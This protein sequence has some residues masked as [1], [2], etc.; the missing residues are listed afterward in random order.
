MVAWWPLNESTGAVVV[1]DIIGFN[2]QGTPKS[3]GSLG[4]ANSPAAIAGQVGGAVNFKSNLQSLATNTGAAN[5]EV[6]DHDEIDFGTGDLSIDAW[7]RM[8]APPPSDAPTQSRLIVGK[9]E[10]T[11]SALATTGTGYALSLVAS[12]ANGASLQFMMG[13]GGPLVS[14]TTRERFVPFDTWT[15]VVVT[16][17]RKGGKVAF[18]INGQLVPATEATMPKGSVS[19]GSSLLIGGSN[20]GGQ[21]FL[22]TIFLYPE[23]SLDEIEMFKRLLTSPEIQS[24]FNAGPSGKCRAT[25]NGLKFNDL[26]GNGARDPGEPG[27]ANWTIKITDSSGNTQTVTTDSQGNYSF[28]VPAPG[29]YTLSEVLQSGWTQTAPSSGSYTVSVLPGQLVNNRDFG[30][31]KKQQ[32]D[33]DL[34]I[35]KEGKPNPVVSGQQVAFIITVQNVGHGP[36]YGPVTV[37][38]S[39][40]PVATAGSG[41]ICT[42]ANCT[43]GAPINPGTGASVTYTY[44]VTEKPGTIFKNCVT[45]KSD[46]DVN[47]ANNEACIEVKVDEAKAPDPKGNLWDVILV[48][49]FR[50]Q[51]NVS[52]RNGCKKTHDFEVTP[53]DLPFLQLQDK[54][55]VKVPGASTQNLPVIFDTRGLQ[56]G[57]YEGKVE[58]DCK[59]CR[60][61]KG[62]TQD[63]QTIPVRLT[64]TPAPTARPPG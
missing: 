16:V 1:N 6:P 27:L 50:G 46:G 37:T 36:C 63:R 55:T 59:T 2:N 41:W 19:N 35:R 56:P 31:K 10:P 13:D 24:I 14:Y 33:C 22:N 23:V 42:G 29:T 15:H 7:V 45:L 40:P 57:L 9:L 4:S 60:Q 3:G 26:N 49:G 48:V 25:I 28:T 58:V 18:Y 53:R 11:R 61:E 38:E 44:N 51:S 52:L 64:V 62:C 30:N 32:E 47:P 12:P 54:A 5:I 8:L 21:G 39:L 43:Y 20:I 34:Q 17:D